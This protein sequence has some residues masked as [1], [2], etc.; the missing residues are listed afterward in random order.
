[1]FRALWA[2]FLTELKKLFTYKVELWASVCCIGAARIATGYFLWRAIFQSQP[3]VLTYGGRTFEQM[4]QYYVFATL[5][6]FAVLPNPNGIAPDIYEGQLSK[7]LLYPVPYLLHKFTTQCAELL[8]AIVQFFVGVGIASVVF[9]TSI[10]EGLSPAG[11]VAY[12]F[13]LLLSHL[14]FFLLVALCELVGFW[15]DKTTSL[16]VMLLFLSNIFAGVNLPLSVFPQWLATI[17]YLTPFPYFVSLPVEALFTH[18]EIPLMPLLILVS[19][20][21]IFVI[22]AKIEWQKGLKC[23]SGV[24][25]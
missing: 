3:D 19:W 1:M 4:V 25:I 24:G 21:I 12:F 20:N 11:F 23:Y 8:L 5:T 6:F 13:L 7:Y 22:I 9:G 17:A 10:F 2:I 14:A 18:G 16:W 15:S